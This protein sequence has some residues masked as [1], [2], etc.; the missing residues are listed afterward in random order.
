MDKKAASSSMLFPM[1]VSIPIVTGTVVLIALLMIIASQFQTRNLEI[2]PLLI[3][4]VTMLVTG[5]ASLFATQW[6][7]GKKHYTAVSGLIGVT[8]I[9]IVPLLMVIVSHIIAEKSVA[10]LVFS[11]FV[12][13]YL[14]F[15]PVGTWLILPPKP[16]KGKDKA[17]ESQSNN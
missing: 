8:T 2:I 15:L 9:M 5:W 17:D 6:A 10:R 12:V 1:S 7:R 11:Y 3:C 14:M 16:P 4:G 13:Y